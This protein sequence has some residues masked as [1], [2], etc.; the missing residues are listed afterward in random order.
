ML[1]AFF[2][3]VGASRCGAAS[4]LGCQGGYS[5]DAMEGHGRFRGASGLSYEGPFAGGAAVEA[6][7]EAAFKDAEGVAAQAVFC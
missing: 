1:T 2:C 3:F 7:T 5:A 6:P 4:R